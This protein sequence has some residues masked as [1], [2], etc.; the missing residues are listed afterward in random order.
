ME[1]QPTKTIDEV[2]ERLEDVLKWAIENKSAVGI[3]PSLYIVV[4]EKIKEGIAR[5]DIFED[6]ARMERLDVHFANRYLEA[7]W[8]FR[9]DPSKVDHSWKLAFLV[10]ERFPTK[11]ILQE[12]LI[13]INA[14]INLDLGIAAARTAPGDAIHALKKD[15]DTVNAILQALIDD[16]KNDISDLSPRF[17]W[18]VRHM[19]AEDAIMD[20]SIRIA[21]DEAWKLA[22]RLAP[23]SGDAFKAIVNEKDLETLKLG[24]LIVSPGFI[25]K[26]IVWWVKRKEDRDV[27]TIIN[28]LRRLAKAKI[29]FPDE[30]RTTEEMAEEKPQNDASSATV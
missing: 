13:G 1:F 24:R 14:H 11:V 2:I 6:N 28:K 22:N 5:G 26:L 8:Q 17:G 27:P 23:R 16:V 25:G 9:H 3:F 7:F 20:F 12:M 30:H 15:F 10:G 19:V 29:K 4:T 21:R 18:I